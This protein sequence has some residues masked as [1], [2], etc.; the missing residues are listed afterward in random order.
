MQKLMRGPK[1]CWVQRP[2]MGGA[3]RTVS[4]PIICVY[5]CMRGWIALPS[6]V[7]TTIYPPVSSLIFIFGERYSL[8]PD[9]RAPPWKS[10]T[11]ASFVL[12]SAHVTRF[13]VRGYKE[14]ASCCTSR[15]SSY[16]REDTP[17]SCSILLHEMWRWWP[18]FYPPLWILRIWPH[19]GDDRTVSQKELKSL[20]S[21]FCSFY[22]R[23]GLPTMHCS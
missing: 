12:G 21:N 7:A 13:W 15:K 5:M 6:V 8:L 23:S 16:K 11:P 17:S 4:K 19:S 14:A 2:S 9:T 3:L 10:Y 1:Q 18:E 20:I 22:S